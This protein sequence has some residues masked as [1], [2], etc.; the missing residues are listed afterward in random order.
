MSLTFGQSEGHGKVYQQGGGQQFN[1]DRAYFG[2]QGLVIPWLPDPSSAQLVAEWDPLELGVHRSRVLSGNAVPPYVERDMDDQISAQLSDARFR[3]G[4]VL[5]VGDS[6]AGKSRAAYEAALR[7]MPNY[8]LFVPEDREELRAAL[9]N[10]ITATEPLALWLDDVERYLGQ[11]GL[12][13]RV[14][15]QLRAARIVAIATLRSSEYRRII[16]ADKLVEG[17][18]SHLKSN[19]GAQILD[20]VEPLILQRRWSSREIDSAREKKDERLLDAVAHAET[21]GVAE[22]LTAGPKL[23]NEW[24]LAWEAG[25]NPRGAA[26]IAAAIDFSRAGLTERIPLDLLEASHDFYLQDAGGQLLGP[27]PFAQ[28]MQWAQ[29][30]RYGVTGMLI[31]AKDP[32]A[33]RVFDYL[34]DAYVRS[35]EVTPIPDFIWDVAESGLASDVNRMHQV[36]MSALAH[37]RFD[38]AERLWRKLAA[39]NDLRAMHRLGRLMRRLDRIPESEEWFRMGAESGNLDSAVELGVLCEDRGRTSDAQG[40]YQRAAD[41]A[42]SHGMLHLG[43]LYRSL[44]QNKEAEY[45]LRKSAFGDKKNSVGLG[46]LLVEMGRLDE[47]ETWLMQAA[48]KGSFN[49]LLYIGIVCADSG[50]E[51]E[52]GQAW[53][54]VLLESN[55]E[56]T[57]YA[58]A[59]NLAKLEWKNN[60]HRKAEGLYKTALG[61]NRRDTLEQYG[62][63][64]LERGRLREAE[65]LLENSAEDGGAAFVLGLVQLKIEKLSEAESHLRAAASSNFKFALPALAGMLDD[66]G[67]HQ[68]ALEFWTRASSDGDM[69]ATFSLSLC[70]RKL[71]RGKEADQRLKEAAAGGCVEALCE[72]GTSFYRKG[73]MG[74]AVPILEDALERGHGHAGCMLGNF[75]EKSGRLDDAVR[76]Y[77]RA[78]GAGHTHVAKDL[79]NLFA[80]MGRGGDAA[81]WLRK[82]KGVSK[83][84]K[85]EKSSRRKK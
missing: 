66:Q 10:L 45:W 63:F 39:A 23:Y 22:Y 65:Q 62:A 70:L 25:A 16:N 24:R 50:R 4:L 11:S 52:A 21:F 82:S 8:R 53:S 54:K 14:L 36:G 77:I 6:T 32:G 18:D 20:L 57:R 47:A 30:R 51:D 37:D 43:L 2:A 7:V 33:L 3:G 76:F 84:R 75:F 28:A 27:E 40:W 60:R 83:R 15:A 44:K 35:A 26:V 61:I 13:A 73:D 80:Q 74:N 19:P 42:D 12:T 67:R 68:E 58:A 59:M 48:E 17:E 85:P 81:I 31:A 34:P 71:G 29:K 78:Y 69:D 56:D 64:L 79:A 72:L 38:V 55:R 5:I 41:A 46:A 49:A 1:V 9:P